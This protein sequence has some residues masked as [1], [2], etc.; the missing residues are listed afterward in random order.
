MTD[1]LC[2]LIYLEHNVATNK[3]ILNVILDKSCVFSIII[4]VMRPKTKCRANVTTFLLSSLIWH[5]GMLGI[6]AK[7]IFI[8][9]P[10]CLFCLLL[11]SFTVLCCA[12]Y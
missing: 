6:Q 11:H 10:V 1:Y 4:E 9:G 8:F 3:L 7:W 5:K 2:I 12:L